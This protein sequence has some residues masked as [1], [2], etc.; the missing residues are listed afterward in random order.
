VK[1]DASVAGRRLK[2]LTPRDGW[3]SFDVPSLLDHE[4]VVIS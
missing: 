3:A 1:L 4:V 2:R